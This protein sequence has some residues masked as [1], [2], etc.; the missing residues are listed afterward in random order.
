MKERK[1]DEI[2]LKI[3]NVEEA[4]TLLNFFELGEGTPTQY[5]LI[6]PNYYFIEI[7]DF[8]A[9]NY[10]FLSNDP[11]DLNYSHLRNMMAE[12]NV[13]DKIFTIQDLY[14]IKNLIK[15]G[16]IRPSYEPKKIIK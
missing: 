13:Y 5:S 4:K 3:N 14:I 12:Y 2:V 9:A 8:K 6:H 10:T 15:Y 1:F 11:R 16:V 7:R